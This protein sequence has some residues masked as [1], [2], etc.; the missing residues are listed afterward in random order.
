MNLLLPS[1]LLAW[2]KKTARK[3]TDLADSMVLLGIMLAASYWG[4]ESLLNVFS[5]ED[6]S[7]YRRIFGPDVNDIWMRIIALCLFVIFGSHVQ[8]TINNRKK[9]EEKLLASYRHLQNAR[10]ATI[11]GLAKLAE[12]RDEGTGLHLERIR[13]YAKLLADEMS[14]LPKYKD[15]INADYIE[16]IYNSSI[17]HDIGKVGIP[18][19]I[20][21]KPG[22][23]SEAEFQQIKQHTV[24]GGDAIRA[25]ESNLEGR[26][27]LHLG[28]RIAYNHHEKWDGSGYPR[29]LKGEAI[30]LSARIVSLADVY[31]AL[32]TKRFYKEAF[33]HQKAKR[34]IAEMR[35]TAFEPEMVDAFLRRE[36][37]FDK[38]RAEKKE[39]VI[40][41][42]VTEHVASG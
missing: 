20:L 23:L 33:S 30:P 3:P 17:L 35:D 1:R 18:D 24:F 32:T 39:D 28:K 4:L 9:A 29:G 34:I 42:E 15:Y 25:I 26:S 6:I 37:D 21:L 12:Y 2:L 11:L 27:F 38:I 7:F 16:D 13:E 22:P 8:Y 5:P 19:A 36:A 40:L 41:P 14:K 31:D 10:T